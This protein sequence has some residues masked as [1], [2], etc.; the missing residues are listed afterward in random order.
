MPKKVDR[1][2]QLANADMERLAEDVA[3][4][5]ALLVRYKAHDLI[6]M[7]LD[8]LEDRHLVASLHQPLGMNK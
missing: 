5:R 8:G 6:P 2:Q 7:L 1:T 4:V 3:K